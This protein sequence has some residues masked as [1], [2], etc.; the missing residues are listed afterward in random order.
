MLII[1]LSISIVGIILSQEYYPFNATIAGIYDGTISKC[2]LIDNNKIDVIP[3][4]KDVVILG[5]DYINY[6]G[7]FVDII[8]QE[9]D[10]LTID[11]LR[12]IEYKDYG[13]SQIFFNIKAL[14]LNDTILLN[15]IVFNLS[16]HKINDTIELTTHRA[17]IGDIGSGKIKKEYLL[18]Q[19]GLTIFP[20]NSGLSIQ[21]F[22][23]HSFKCLGISSSFDCKRNKFGSNDLSRFSKHNK[24]DFL[25][26]T[27]I[28]VKDSLGKFYRLPPIV[29]ELE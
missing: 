19:N 11:L 27:D 25:I 26:F 7:G 9:S 28:I 22:V 6:S 16:K 8:S 17:Y 1:L 3:H 13:T 2:E 10:S 18:K 14:Y 29:T 12:T 4:D 20:N 15:N 23:Y 21:G 5:Y 24:G